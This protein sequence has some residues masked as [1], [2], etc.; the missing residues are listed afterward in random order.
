MGNGG[1]ERVMSTLANELSSENNE[2]LILSLTTS[3]SFY[4]LNEKV[5]M[6][7]ANYII[8]R[9]SKILRRIDM[10]VNGIKGIFFVRSLVK[11]WK[12]DIV[13]SFLTHTNILSIITKFSYKNMKLIVSERCDPLERSL[14]LRLLT[15]YLYPFADGIVCQSKVVAEFFP[16]TAQKNIKIIQNPINY[17]SVSNKE[18]SIKRKVIVGVGRLFEQKN[19]ELLIDSFNDI[20]DDFPLHKLEI[21]GEGHLRNQLESQIERL[22]LCNRVFLRGVINNVM[23]H[24]SDSELFV[25]SSN[26]EGFPNALIEAM[27]S[28]LPVISTD[29]STGVARDLIKE[30]NGII[31]PVGDQ[32]SLTKAMRTILSSEEL[33]KKMSIENRCLNNTLSVK[34]ILDKWIELF[35]DVISK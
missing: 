9:D 19:F 29:F 7:G 28:G 32:E 26:F 33:Q 34:L 21:Y 17:E 22:D 20:K 4:K 18:F 14:T 31:V 2:V 6:V 35:V 27:A 15:K 12:P 11:E 5:K 24:V 8:S 10:L 3:D 30:N 25:L 13:I 23:K 1:A 16:Q